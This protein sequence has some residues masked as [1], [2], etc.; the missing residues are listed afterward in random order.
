MLTSQ[1][2]MINETVNCIRNYLYHC[3]WCTENSCGILCSIQALHWRN[4]FLLV[5][6]QQMTTREMDRVGIFPIIVHV[7]LLEHM[8]VLEKD[9]HEWGAAPLAV[10]M[11]VWKEEGRRLVVT[12]MRRHPWLLLCWAHPSLV[13]T[14][15]KY[16]FAFCLSAFPRS[17]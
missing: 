2:G 9:W 13:L 14:A 10:Y 11:E 16:Y 1:I 5:E 12:A 6:I 17:V 8:W 7:P 4:K 3:T 15:R